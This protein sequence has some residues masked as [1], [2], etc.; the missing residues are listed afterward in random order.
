MNN[1]IKVATNG[2]FHDVIQANMFENSTRYV[3]F[4][5]WKIDN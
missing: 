5:I 1:F 3:Y 2:K 4:D